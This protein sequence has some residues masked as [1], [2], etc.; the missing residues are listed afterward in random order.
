M[1]F[2]KHYYR[3]GIMNRRAPKDKELLENKLKSSTGWLYRYGIAFSAVVVVLSL[4]NNLG[5]QIA[6][7]L[8][9]NKTQTS[10]VNAKLQPYEKPA[11]HVF[12]NVVNNADALV[13][14][15]NVAS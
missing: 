9:L 2:Q 7:K 12:S 5:A 6:N 3:D 11:F 15:I 14:T 13:H 8:G 4:F 1:C 10:S